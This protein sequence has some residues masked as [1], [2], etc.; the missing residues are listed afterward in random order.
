MYGYG[1]YPQQPYG[2]PSRV[3]P[4][5]ELATL[6]NP[7][8]RDPPQLI[9]QWHNVQGLGSLPGDLGEAEVES[10]DLSQESDKDSRSEYSSFPTREEFD[11]LINNYIGSL[12]SQKQDK[13]FIDAKRARNIR[14]I[15]ISPKGT[16][17][18]TSQFRPIRHMKHRR[19]ICHRGK[20]VAIRE[21][22]F[23][24]LTKAHQK[25]QHGGRDKTFARIRDI[26]SW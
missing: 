25:C 7:R 26:Y 14:A 6:D 23:K 17:V 16:A 22:L 8:L 15:L 2:P 20:P 21:K 24:I 10:Q 11:Q 5:P 18:E 9:P 3:F 12:A 4:T 19:M 1:A 13:A